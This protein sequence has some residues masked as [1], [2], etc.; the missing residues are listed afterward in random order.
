M[1][2]EG[3]MLSKNESDRE[4]QA[5]Y[6]IKYME[7]QQKSKVKLIETKRRKLVVKS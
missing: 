1:G 4:R 7:S 5:L 6:G 3:I 2:L